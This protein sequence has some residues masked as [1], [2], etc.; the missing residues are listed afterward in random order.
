M[1]KFKQITLGL[2]GTALLATGLY[3]CSNDNETTDV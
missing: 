3:S 1:N 2:L